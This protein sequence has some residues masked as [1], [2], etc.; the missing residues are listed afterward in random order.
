MA[1]VGLVLGAGGVVGAA[2]HEGVL[3]AINDVTGWDPRTAD[4]I[5][6]TS[7]G[8]YVGARLRAGA[9][10]REAIGE[11]PGGRPGGAVDPAGSSRRAPAAIGAVVRGITRPGSARVGAMVAGALP[12]G[13]HSTA[14]MITAVNKIHRRG[15]PEHPL[16]LPAVRLRDGA[17]VVFGREGAPPTDVGHAVA[18]SCAIP[19]YFTPVAIGGERY[20]DGGTHSPTNLDLLADQDLDLVVVVAPMGVARGVFSAAAAAQGRSIFRLRLGREAAA[21][22]RGGARVV[23]FSPTAA[24]LE[25]MG[26][27]SMAFGRRP[28]VV[29]RARE[30]ALRRLD[31]PRWAEEL[32]LLHAAPRPG[33]ANR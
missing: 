5:V 29:K 21:V 9:P 23:A 13:R 10:V 15:W 7:A 33:A 22:R 1:R 14:S 31:D 6:G 11:R 19:A 17:R 28:A 3:R 18:A 4:I 25:V 30:S 12:A 20:V 2:F 24:D 16:W 26:W 27:N 8:S 32:A